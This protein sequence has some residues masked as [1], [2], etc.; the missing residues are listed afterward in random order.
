ML[1]KVQLKVKGTLTIMV[2]AENGNIALSE[3]KQYTVFNNIEFENEG[4]TCPNEDGEAS[5]LDLSF[6][7]IDQDGEHRVVNL[8][9]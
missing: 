8:N 4:Y 3:A 6:D 5:C 7:S 9:D 2:E 1:F